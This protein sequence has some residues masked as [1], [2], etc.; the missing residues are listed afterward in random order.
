MQELYKNESELIVVFI[1][2][3][4]N[5]KQWCGVEWRGIRKLLNDKE[6][7]NRILFVKYGKGEVDGV[8][9]VLDGYLDSTKMSIDFIVEDIVSRYYMIINDI[10]N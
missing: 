8:F 6:D 1:C 7:E 2:S 10:Y 4:Y 9:G 5:R 3:D